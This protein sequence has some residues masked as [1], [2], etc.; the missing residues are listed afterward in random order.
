[1][2]RVLSGIQPSG[3]VHLGNYVGALRR[4]AGEQDRV[5]GFYV[6]V[7]LHAVTVAHDPQALRDRSLEL[8]AILFAAGLDP[9]RSTVFVQ[10]HLHE[11]AELAWLLNCVATMGELSRMVQ[12]KEKSKGDE[13]VSV[14][15]FDYPVL[16]AADILLYDADEVPVG[17]DQRQHI[18]L[19]RDIAQRFN[20]RFGEVFT[21]PEATTPKVGARIMDL[22][23]PESKMS[24]S[25]ESP[26]GTILLLDEPDEIRKKVR[27]AV[28]DSGT[29]VRADPESK[30]AVTN[31]LDLYAAVT[32]ADVAELERR[33]EG[34]G[35]AEFKTDLA[36]AVVEFLRP[37]R[38]RYEELVADPTQVEERLATGAGKARAIASQT[39][40]RAK[41]AMGFLPARAGM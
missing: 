35:Y 30:R 31:L 33:Y 16:Q 13:S 24:K 14:G 18:E 22:Q 26:R 25:S 15:L 36:E 37:V 3:E 10:S 27:S 21:L 5:D 6:I 12:W 38:E 29:E 4:W 19:T 11:H 17:D 8:A 41:E 1:M 23:Y 40:E 28:T 9:E 7:D 20:H 2:T 32:D 39:L 34:A